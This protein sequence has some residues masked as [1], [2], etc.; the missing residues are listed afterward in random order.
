MV[1]RKLKIT[2]YASGLK[3]HLLDVENVFSEHAIDETFVT[4]AKNIFFPPSQPKEVH[5]ASTSI[6]TETLSY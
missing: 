2:N 5:A 4:P 3:P 1:R 6:R